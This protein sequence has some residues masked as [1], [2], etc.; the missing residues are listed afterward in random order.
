M[1]KCDLKCAAVNAFGFGGTNAVCVI[2]HPAVL[3]QNVVV[4]LVRQVL[5][6][7][8]AHFNDTYVCLVFLSSL[9][10]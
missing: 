4:V 3:L 2:G 6:G 10:F 8:A 9:L 5:C 1:T 7:L